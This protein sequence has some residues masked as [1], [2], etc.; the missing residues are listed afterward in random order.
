MLWPSQLVTV[1]LYQTLHGKD[2]EDVKETKQRMRFFSYSFASI[3]G[4]QF[5][6]SVIFPTLTSIAVRCVSAVHHFNDRIMTRL[7]PR[8]GPVLDQQPVMGDDD[9]WQRLL[10]FRHP[11]FCELPVFDFH[12]HCKRSLTLRAR[13]AVSRLVCHWWHRR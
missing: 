13:D 5:V 12:S 7:R 9:A 4:W 3:F 2:E 6:P 11:R 8:P 1:S 10:G